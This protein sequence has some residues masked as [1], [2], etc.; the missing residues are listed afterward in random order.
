M[1]FNYGDTV[2]TGAI[3]TL[4]A[5]TSYDITFTFYK[6][7]V[8]TGKGELNLVTPH[9]DTIAPNVNGMVVDRNTTSADFKL[10]SDEAGVIYY[11]FI[12]ENDFIGLPN[13]V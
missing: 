9:D 8:A 6:N 2:G 5:D 10:C 3:K 11:I 4:S 13:K 7:A 12:R 1:F